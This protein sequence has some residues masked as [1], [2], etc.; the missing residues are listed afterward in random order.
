M[1]VRNDFLFLGG[2][3]AVDFLNTEVVSDGAPLDK[4]PDAESLA[5]WLDAAGLGKAPV[6]ARTLAAVKRFRAELRESVVRMAEGHAAKKSVIESIN[7]ALRRGKGALQLH[8]HARRLTVAFEPD[9]AD[10]LFLVARAAADFL[11]TADPKRIRRCEGTNCMLL[12]YDTT[13]SGTRRWC[14]M[15]GCGNRMKAALHYARRSGG[16]A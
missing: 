11:A 5:S 13:K 9:E 1:T 8:A 12:F 3:L 4:L 7:E 6:S 14:S 16:G 15:A 2:D 10:V